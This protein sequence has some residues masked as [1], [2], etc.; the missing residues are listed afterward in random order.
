MNSFWFVLILILVAIVLQII[1]EFI[2]LQGQM[3]V[4][5]DRIKSYVAMVLVSAMIKTDINVY[6]NRC[7]CFFCTFDRLVKKTFINVIVNIYICL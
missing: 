6:A 1:M 5:V 3:I 4:Q 7:V 2:A